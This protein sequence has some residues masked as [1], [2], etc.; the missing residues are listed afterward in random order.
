MTAHQQRYDNSNLNLNNV[1]YVHVNTTKTSKINHT[2][3]TGICFIYRT[4]VLTDQRTYPFA[5]IS[6]NVPEGFQNNLPKMKIK[7]VKKLFYSSSKSSFNSINFF[8][9]ETFFEISRSSPNCLFKIFQDQTSKVFKSNETYR[10]MLHKP[11]EFTKI[12][13]KYR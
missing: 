10:P 9:F 8:F 6:G 11:D 12:D 3:C 13:S 5:Y 1:K 7:K 4:K 2:D